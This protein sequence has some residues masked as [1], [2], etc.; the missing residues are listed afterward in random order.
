MSLLQT[1]EKV[2]R[3]LQKT[4]LIN[5][6]DLAGSERQSKS[7]AKGERLGEAIGINQSLTVLGRVIS[8]LAKATKSEMPPYRQSKLTALLKE[9]LG[10]NALTTLV[11]A[12]SPAD[13]NYSETISTLQFAA[14]CKLVKNTARINLEDSASEA[15]KLREENEKLRMM[16]ARMD[17]GVRLRWVAD[18]SHGWVRIA[19]NGYEWAATG[20]A[21]THSRARRRWK[22]D[23]RHQETIDH[24]P[25]RAPRNLLGARHRAHRR[26]G[27]AEVSVVFEREQRS[28]PAV[29]ARA[30]GPRA[31]YSSARIN[32]HTC[33]KAHHVCRYF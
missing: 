13:D 2:G 19:T 11:A 33:V 21:D 9:S 8:E 15:Q 6:V 16:L 5:L 17:A 18:G 3:K 30:R 26:G 7:G 22:L 29:R 10:G 25:H 28:A 23:D 20:F 4:S 24:V 32:V 14:R 1:S 12:V 27:A 31:A